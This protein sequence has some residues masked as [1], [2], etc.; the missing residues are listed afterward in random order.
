VI[1]FTTDWL[2]PTSQSREIVNALRV[3]GKNVAYTEIETDYGHDAFLLPNER[4]ERDIANFLKRE[5]E[6]ANNEAP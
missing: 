4:M 3:V 6:K 2:Y 5:M 1:G